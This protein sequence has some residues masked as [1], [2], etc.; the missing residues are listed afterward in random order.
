MKSTL[1]TVSGVI[2]SDIREQIADGERPLADYIAMADGF[3]ADLIDFATAAAQANWF[4]RLLGRLAGNNLL[5]AWVCFTLR[6]QYRNIFTDGEQI[7]IPLA[8]FLKFFGFG[9]R[10]KHLMIVHRIDVEKKR[11]LLDIL[12]LYTH[13][14]I[15]LVY[16]TYNKQ[17]IQSRWQ[18]PPERVVFT[19]FMVDHHFFSK[20]AVDADTPIQ[21]LSL[22]GKS[23]I[24]AVGLEFRDYPTLLK[25][26]EGLDVHV[27]VA[28]GSPWS[29]R[30]DSTAGEAI[31][32]NVTVQKFDFLNLR[33]LYHHSQLMV[34]PL[35]NVEFQAGVTAILEGMAMEKPLVC[36]LTPGQTDVIEDGVNGL[37]VKPED[38]AELRSAIVELLDEPAK[39]E[40]LGRK[41]RHTIESEM[42]LVKYVERLRQYL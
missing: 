30:T 13:I 17:F 25:A 28:A 14:D 2:P 40:E 6:T 33:R 22:N 23:L 5:L 15:F 34:M 39:A 9:Q 8:F 35:Y 41:A 21:N 29:K 20:S 18:L 7:G 27:V 3:D 31:P 24:C 4:G 11:R 26:V 12:R 36:S 38:P 32:D 1:L 10:A 16:N 42:S 19:P 37:Y